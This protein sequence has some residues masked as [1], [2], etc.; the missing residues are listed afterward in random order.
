MYGGKGASQ[1]GGIR[2]GLGVGYHLSRRNLVFLRVVAGVGVYF[3]GGI[4]AKRSKTF[5]SILDSSGFSKFGELQPDVLLSNQ[6]ITII[7]Y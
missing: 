6:A 4:R 5:Q 7:T 1:S 2:G 3:W